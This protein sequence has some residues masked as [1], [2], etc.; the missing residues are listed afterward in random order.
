MVGRVIRPGLLPL[1]LILLSLS[2][3]AGATKALVYNATGEDLNI[4]INGRTSLHPWASPARIYQDDSKVTLK[5]ETAN[6]NGELLVSHL[7]PGQPYIILYQQ[8]K[9][10]FVVWGVDELEDHLNKILEN[11]PA[12]CKAAVFNSTGRPIKFR[13]KKAE[14]GI[15]RELCVFTPNAG[16]DENL[17]FKFLYP[18]LGERGPLARNSLHVVTF[19]EKDG[20]AFVS[21]E[22]WVGGL[23]ARLNGGSAPVKTDATP[24]ARPTS[25]EEPE[26][27][28]ASRSAPQVIQETLKDD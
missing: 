24:P 27:R 2:T 4:A 5:L 3:P 10:Q 7:E 16:S 21:F 22:N 13:F 17:R 23:M 20:Y 18:E 25:R 1:L 14:Q 19:E 9:E 8:S 15:G 12:S 11:H 6:V 26:T 28:L